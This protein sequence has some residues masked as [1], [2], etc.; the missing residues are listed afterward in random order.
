VHGWAYDL[1]DGVIR[2][3]KMSMEGPGELEA[4]Y[5]TALAPADAVTAAL[6]SGKLKLRDYTQHG[7]TEDTEGTEEEK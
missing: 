7:A 4:C 6:G 5:A 3:L 2:D 1:K